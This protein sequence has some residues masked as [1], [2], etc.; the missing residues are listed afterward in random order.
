[1]LVTDLTFVP[2]E[3]IRAELARRFPAW[4]VVLR[5]QQEGHPL[6]D[7]RIDFHGPHAVEALGMA[8]AAAQALQEFMSSQRRQV[9][10]N[11]GLDH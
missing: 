2:W 10:D 8:H 7:L 6:Q 5:H 4:L 1:V 11:S 3:E 9:R